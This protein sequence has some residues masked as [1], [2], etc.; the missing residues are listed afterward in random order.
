MILKRFFKPIFCKIP[1]DWLTVT[2]SIN[3][4][5]TIGECSPDTDI[6]DAYKE[7]S[8]SVMEKLCQ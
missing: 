3:R 7:L 5:I 4:G 6:Y 1:N 2:E 8:L